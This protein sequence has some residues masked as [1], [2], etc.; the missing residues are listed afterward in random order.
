MLS[1]LKQFQKRPYLLWIVLV[2]TFLVTRLYNLLI[3][4]LFTDESIYIYWAKV[5]ATTHA[6]LFISLTDGKP[7]VLIWMI[8][9]L[10][11]IFPADWYL[12]AGRLPSVIS[13]LIAL[14]AVVKLGE[15][16]FS[17][18]LGIIAG[19]LI[20]IFP[21]S[22]FYD[23]MALFDSMLTSM[24]LVS[25]YFAVKTGKEKK[26]RDAVL[27]GIFLGLAFLSK[28]TALLFMPLTVLAVVMPIPLKSI[29]KHV[30]KLSLLSIF[31]LGIGYGINSLQRVSSAYP[32]MVRKN[33]QFQQPLTE[34]LMNPF[35]LT[36]GNLHGFM[37][38]TIGY[39]TIPVFVIGIAAGC[40]GLYRKSRT[41]LLLCILWFV[42]LFA[43]ATVGREVFPRYILIVVPYF[44]LLVSFG[45]ELIL[46]IKQKLYRM[47]GIIMVCLSLLPLLWFDMLLLTNP[48]QA[49]FPQ[50]D[51]NQYVTEHPSGYGLEET[52]AF[53]RNASANKKITVV[54]QGTFGLY[55]YAYYLE[56]FGDPNITI[57]PKWPL[58]TL[59]QEILTA[60]E[61]GKVYV[62]LKEHDTVPESLPLREVF[63]AEKPGGKYP[64]IITEIEEMP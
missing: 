51:K 23:R 19:I 17:K 39:Y 26:L 54:T 1:M 35:A 22:L 34:L 60:A 27:W 63:R 41:V 40:I 57:L 46:R 62:L 61:K 29:T 10:L 2:A 12:I 42:P 6:Q 64:L 43:L 52:Y 37:Q 32:A 24:L 16:L 50:A 49:P 18:R 25:V 38:W 53:F 14:V 21:M 11:S 30:R 7:P 31:A 58:D 8:A 36:F 59:D 48:A 20:I 55:P 28:P 15:L 13:G 4:P 45:I 5:I 3:L 9:S 47:I 56:F 33:A 44:L